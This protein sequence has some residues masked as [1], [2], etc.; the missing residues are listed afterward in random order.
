MAAIM[1]GA[2]GNIA[3]F[4]GVSRPMVKRAFDFNGIFQR[5]DL[6]RFASLSAFGANSNHAPSNFDWADSWDAGVDFLFRI[7]GAR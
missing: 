1:T 2:A 7:A 4:D 3:Y 6:T 5:T